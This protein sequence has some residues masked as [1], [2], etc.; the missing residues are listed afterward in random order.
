MTTSGYRRRYVLRRAYKLGPVEISL[1][2]EAI[3][4]EARSRQLDVDTFLD[5]YEAE[6]YYGGGID[7]LQ[8]SF[9]AKAAS[10]SPI[11]AQTVEP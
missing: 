8:I 10:E 6:V 9:V 1:P 11:P 7:G 4:Y 5:T 3:E 2:Y